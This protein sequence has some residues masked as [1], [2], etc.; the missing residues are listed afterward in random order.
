MAT[1][2]GEQSSREGCSEE[3]RRQTISPPGPD[4]TLRSM[5]SRSTVTQPVGRDVVNGRGVET[6]PASPV[7]HYRDAADMEHCRRWAVDVT[8]PTRPNV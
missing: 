2:G 4:A 8:L 5:T 6:L 1:G 7:R 3:Y